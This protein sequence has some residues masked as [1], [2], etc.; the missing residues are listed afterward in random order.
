MFGV[1]FDTIPDELGNG[2]MIGVT[3]MKKKMASAWRELVLERL[4]E[5][6]VRERYVFEGLVASHA[7]MLARNNQLA[8]RTKQLETDL[9]LAQRGG[10]GAGSGAADAS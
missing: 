2:T 4:R 1:E 6:N 7:V 9:V 5:R 8:E 10:G 3:G